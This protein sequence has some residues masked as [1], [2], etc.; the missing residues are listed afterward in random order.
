M[1]IAT[2]T[3]DG[4][5]TSLM[6]G[7]RVPKTHPRVE[8]YGTVDELNAALGMARALSGDDQVTS[9]LLATQKDLIALMGELAVDH[10]D[11]ARYQKAGYPVA[12]IEMLERQDNM[13]AAMES[14]SIRFEGWAT[15]GETPAA[16]ALDVARTVCRRAERQLLLLRNHHIE[17]NPLAVQTLNR[18]ADALWLLARYE[19]TQKTAAKHT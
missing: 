15:P 3:G 19:E 11:A 16:A 12:T 2:K 7:K 6:F 14:R 13:V 18:L 17:P 9:H 1:S 4:G 5:E 10:A 8:A